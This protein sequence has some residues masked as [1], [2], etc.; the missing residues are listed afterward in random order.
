MSSKIA[1][2][3]SHTTFLQYLTQ[4]HAKRADIHDVRPFRGFSRR[5]AHSM[6][7]VRHNGF[8]SH[9]IQNAR[10]TKS[11]LDLF[12]RRKRDLNQ[13]YDL[14]GFRVICEVQLPP[15]GGK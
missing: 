13:S 14:L 15:A 8:R 10:H 1:T 2:K 7:D 4:I 11:L 12:S 3:L 9:V 5:L 6:D